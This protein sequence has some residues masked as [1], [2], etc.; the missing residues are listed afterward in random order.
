MLK[1]QAMGDGNCL[2]NAEAVSLMTAF[3]QKKL[4]PLFKNKQRLT[5][6]H[7]LLKIFQNNE[8]I[9]VADTITQ[10]SVTDGFNSLVERFTV[11][12]EI[13]WVDLQ[14]QMAVGLRE[15]VQD[16]MINDEAMRPALRAE[17]TRSLDQYVEMAFNGEGGARGEEIDLTAVAGSIFEGMEVIE[18]KIQEILQDEELESADAKKVALNEWFFEGEATGFSEYLQG[19]TGIGNPTIFAGPVELNVLSAKLG[20]VHKT[21]MQNTI[22]QDN[23]LTLSYYNAFKPREEARR[24]AKSAL[25]FSFEKTPNHWNCLFDNTQANKAM[26]EKHGMHLQSVEREKILAEHESYE[27]HRVSLDITQKE[28][29][30]LYHLTPKQFKNNTNVLKK[31]SA[32]DEE[33]EVE[34]VAV[35]GTKDKSHT[36]GAKKALTAASQDTKDVGFWGAAAIVATFSLAVLFPM[37]KTVLFGGAF[38]ASGVT[39][40]ALTATVAVGCFAGYLLTTNKISE[41]KEISEVAG[42]KAPHKAVKSSSSPKVVDLLEPSPTLLVY[43]NTRAQQRKRDIA[44]VDLEKAP[45]PPRQKMH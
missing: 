19:E 24:I 36:A 42:K 3:M 21:Y 25:V 23:E 40:F 12:D 35:S 44:R 37:I 31:A 4:T 41:A 27:A 20:I 26:I 5:Q 15:Y 9:E 39:F 13:D 33:D 32:K 8:L 45:V 11:G 2:Y 17:L 22:G 30:D 38:A 29:C 10:K 34:V 7:R 18:A 1:F 14:E 6:F 28:Y 43:Q 16:V